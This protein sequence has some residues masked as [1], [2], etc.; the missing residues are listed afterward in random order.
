[1]GNNGSGREFDT[2]TTGSLRRR[3]PLASRGQSLD[4]TLP[5]VP[6]GGSQWVACALAVLPAAAPGAQNGRKFCRAVLF[7]SQVARCQANEA[8]GNALPDR[9]PVVHQLPVTPPARLH[10]DSAACT[11][12]QTNPQVSLGGYLS[13]PSP[14]NFYLVFF[15]FL[16]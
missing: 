14:P 4:W 7:F 10:P 9:L 6:T 13:L 3:R 5:A 11:R 2:I 8:A 12:A 1:M 16:L 15:P